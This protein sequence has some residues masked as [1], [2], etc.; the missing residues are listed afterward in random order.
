MIPEE[1]AIE[2]DRAVRRWHQLPLDRAT[3]AL[4]V[5]LDLLSGLAGQTVPDLG[6]AVAMDQLKVIV[7]DACAHD[8][9]PEALGDRLASL[10]LS[11][12]RDHGPGGLTRR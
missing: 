7:H 1:V 4:P 8:G 10:R 2:V 3:A 6:P 5:L 12:S 9:A 11:W